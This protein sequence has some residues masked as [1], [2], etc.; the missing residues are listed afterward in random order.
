[1]DDVRDIWVNMTS[2]C[3]Y[4]AD[5]SFTILR[6]GSIWFESHPPPELEGRG[7]RRRP[8]NFGDEHCMPSCSLL[9]SVI[10]TA[11]TQALQAMGT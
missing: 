2:S 9:V 3:R 11:T 8:E 5:G 4:L 10:Q 6:D 7:R 1:M